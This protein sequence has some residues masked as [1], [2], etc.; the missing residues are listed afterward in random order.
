MHGQDIAIPLGRRRDMPL[1]AAA[2]AATRD[3]TM[4]FPF[5]ARRRLAGL[6]L[7]ATDVDWSVGQGAVVEGP[8]AALLLVLTGRPA[9]LAA[10]SGDGMADLTSRLCTPRR[11]ARRS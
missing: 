5:Y 8:I 7:D 1:E 9:G 4:G 2:V 3:W 10:L 6:R 11:A